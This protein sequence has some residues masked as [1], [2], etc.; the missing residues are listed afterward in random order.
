M[1]ADT[2]RQR[3]RLCAANKIRIQISV[4]L[5]LGLEACRCGLPYFTF[6]IPALYAR[7]KIILSMTGS[8][9]GPCTRVEEP[10]VC[11]CFYSLRDAPPAHPREA[12]CMD[13]WREINKRMVTL[14][15]V[16]KPK[17]TIARRASLR[18]ESS[19]RQAKGFDGICFVEIDGR[20][21]SG[22]ETCIFKMRR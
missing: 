15:S 3:L 14:E 20:K 11:F 9:N 17:M 19:D 7:T 8:P 18:V 2:E 13:M 21:G 4:R 6:V 16:L 12:V 22:G 10:S 1:K 5:D